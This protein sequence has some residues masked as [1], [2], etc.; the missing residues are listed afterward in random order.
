MHHKWHRTKLHKITMC[1][2]TIN[3]TLLPQSGMCILPIPQSPI[4]PSFHKKSMSPLIMPNLP[5]METFSGIG[6]TRGER[7]TLG[8]LWQLGL[9]QLPLATEIPYSGSVGQGRAGQLPM[10]SH[11]WPICLNLGPGILRM[12]RP[13][14]KH[15]STGRFS[16]WLRES[17]TSWLV[18]RNR[19]YSALVF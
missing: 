13:H 7:D 6:T 19:F 5:Q 11:L 12:Y 16:F 10:Q 15:I 1:T 8:Y 9:S 18:S 17:I 2:Q 3:F 14:K 4:S